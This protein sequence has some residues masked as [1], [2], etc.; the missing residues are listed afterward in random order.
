M[1]IKFIPNQPILF[2]ADE[3]SCKN[4]DNKSYNQLL[5][6][7]DR[8]HLQLK[9]DPCG[10]ELICQPQ[11][12]GTE[13]LTNPDFDG[14]ASGWTLGTDVTY[15]GLGGITFNGLGVTPLSQ[16]QSLA[17]CFPY[18]LTVVVREYT[19]GALACFIGETLAGKITS[20]GTHTFIITPT[21]DA[22]VRIQNDPD[23]IGDYLPINAV[24]ESVSLKPMMQCVNWI[25]LQRSVQLVE[26]YNFTATSDPW[27]LTGGWAYDGGS[28]IIVNTPG[29]V[30]AAY[31][32]IDAVQHRKGYAIS[33]SALV[34]SGTLTVMFGNVEIGTI[35]ANGTYDYEYPL[36]T[37]FNGTYDKKAFA[38][39]ASSDFDGSVSAARI[40]FNESIAEWT[41]D[42]ICKSVTDVDALVRLDVSAIEYND[43]IRVNVSIRNLIAGTARV[44]K[45]TFVT[46][47][48][49]T[50]LESN[51]D[52]NV[53]IDPLGTYKEYIYIYLTQN[54]EGCV[55]PTSA[56]QFSTNHFMQINAFNGAQVS[57]VYYKASPQ[58][59]VIYHQD[60]I[61]WSIDFSFVLIGEVYEQM[62]AGCYQIVIGDYCIEDYWIST[63]PISYSPTPIPCSE[64]VTAYCND[65]AF[66]FDFSQGF[67]L[68]QRLRILRISPKYRVKGDE[69][70]YSDGKNSMYAADTDK[71]WQ[72]WFNYCDEAAHDAIAVQLLCDRLFIGTD[73]YYALPQD[74]EPEWAT[75][76]K[77]NLAQSRVD[78]KKKTSKLYKRNLQ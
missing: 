15:D 71:V 52:F 48:E 14:D 47:T 16:T 63:T 50:L 23:N 1:A 26:N 19:T 33:V 67:K 78:L 61:T 22:E 24:V 72:A 31:Q 46:Y 62:E 55:N 68:A 60:F 5:Q 66:G 75:N 59:P 45:D 28:G 37:I 64:Y 30:G 4:N 25:D 57:D 39:V 77:R 70:T 9:H 8:L 69:Y 2:E 49:G 34:T 51:G 38:L 10:S 7:G 35:T 40:D 12:L 29:V 44:N 73:E 36:P 74:Y 32:V 18:T 53:Y 27:V 11:D 43:L 76:M 58:D 13:V 20:I 56:K 21:L 17:V 6:A 3:Q 54:F 41:Q 42:G 65:A